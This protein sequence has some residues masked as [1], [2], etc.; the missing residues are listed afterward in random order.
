M[1]VHRVWADV[2]GRQLTSVAAAPDD[3]LWLVTGD[4]EVLLVSRDG[5]VDV[6]LQGPFDYSVVASDPEGRAWLVRSHEHLAFRPEFGATPLL[7]RLDAEGEA[8]ATLGLGVIPRDFLLAH[9]AS[10]GRIAVTDSI[11]YYAPFIRDEV[12]ALSTSGDTLWVTRRGLPQ[13]T[14]EPR[15]EINNGEP[16]IDYAPVNLGIAVG[17]DGRLYVLS[18]PGFT[19]SEGRLD[20]V[21]AETGHLVRTGELPGPLPTLAADE[22]GRVY[23]LDELRLLTGVPPVERPP[24]QAFDLELLGGGGD[25]MSLHD[26]AGRVALINFWASWCGPCRTE[27]P[28][29]DALQKSIEDDDFIFVTMN[30]DVNPESAA[31]FL[32]A[33]GFEFP[34]VLGRGRLRAKYHYIGLPFTVLLDRE[35][36]VVQRW[37]GFAGEQQIQSIRAVVTAELNREMGEMGAGGGHEHG[38]HTLHPTPHPQ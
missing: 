16:M 27:M 15:F 26:L 2:E 18:V 5:G 1:R 34:S 9:L 10:S 20:V 7:V 33:Y 29:L 30:E 12:V 13:S 31:E 11:I 22:E 24:F 36:R 38:G 8:D 32:S 28:A 4:G 23:L 14:A 37:I 25:R 35:G 21:D 17:P 19:T 3:G 6:N